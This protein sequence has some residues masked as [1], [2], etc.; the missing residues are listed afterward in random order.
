[1]STRPPAAGLCGRLRRICRAS[2]LFAAG[3][4]N[5]ERRAVRSEQDTADLIRIERTRSHATGD[6]DLVPGFVNVTVAS[7]AARHGYDFARTRESGD[8]FRLRI[9]GESQVPRRIRINQLHH[10]QT[11]VAIGHICEVTDVGAS[12]GYIVSVVDYTVG[13]KEDGW[14]RLLRVLHVNDCHPLRTRRYIGEG[15]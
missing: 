9:R 4:R 2:L 15:P 6:R 10:A 1:M 12:D 13:G 8:Q 14:L 11:V 3:S 5:L 7:L